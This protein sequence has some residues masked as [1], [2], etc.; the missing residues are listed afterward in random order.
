TGMDPTALVLEITEGTLMQ[1]DAQVR[2]VIAELKALGVRL[3]LD[4]FGTGYSSLSYLHQFPV[5]ILKIDRVFVTGLGHDPATAA[6]VASVVNLAHALGISVIAEGVET[7]EQ[8]NE[9]VALGCESAQGFWY[10][11]GMRSRELDALL[12]SSH[13]QALCLPTTDRPPS[14][15]SPERAA[16]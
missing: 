14:G 4:D 13:G 7:P 3:A 1:D 2:T 6:I 15:A 16:G 8:R 5:D 11:P 10:A 12:G 9:I